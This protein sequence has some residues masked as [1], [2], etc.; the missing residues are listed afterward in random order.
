[1]RSWAAFFVIFTVVVGASTV[2]AWAD[3]FQLEEF[4]NDTDAYVPSSDPFNDPDLDGT[5]P[6]EW[7]DVRNGWMGLLEEVPSGHLGVVSSSGLNHGVLY[8]ESGSGPFGFPAYSDTGATEVR[9]F[10]DIFA[11]PALA[12]NGDGSLDFWFSNALS[13]TSGDYYSESGIAGNV[14]ENGQWRFTTTSGVQIADVLPGSWY[15][16]EATYD[17]S[18]PN[19]VGHYSVY[20]QS[21]TVLFGSAILPALAGNPA[22]SALG[23]PYYAWFT[24]FTEN[25]DHLT[26]DQLG[27]ASSVAVPEPGTVALLGMGALVLVLI[28]R[29]R[30]TVQI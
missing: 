17:G 21:G 29:R 30:R 25:I 9:F 14:L 11:D 22:S 12:S 3:S 8:P 5:P 1:M 26:V 19:V 24:N 6:A 20:D 7:S 2:P 13:N 18:G 28:N 16:L 23:G 10:T 15:Q 27:A 4:D